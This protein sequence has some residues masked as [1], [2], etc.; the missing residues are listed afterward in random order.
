MKKSTWFLAG[1]ALC[2]VAIP[3]LSQAAPLVFEGGDGI[4]KGKHIVLI[5]GD[6]EYRSEEVMPMLG[7]ILSK[8]HGFK[9]SVVF[10]MSKDGTFIDPKNQESLEGL[11]ALE[12]ADL[13]MIATRF[14]K[15]AEGMNFVDDYLA[16][17]KPVIGLR[18]ATHGF[19]GLSGKYAR[20]NNGYGGE[21]W[22][23]GFGREVLGEKW[24]NHHGHH[25]KESTMGVIVESE[26]DHPVLR[27]IGKWQIWGPTDVYG[28]RLPLPG[29][30]KPLVLGSVLEGMTPKDKAVSGKKNDPM[31]PVVWTKSYQ[32]KDG[33]KG[34]VL[35][36]TMGAS[37][38]FIEPGLRRLVINGVL[39][40]LGMEDKI[41]GKENVDVVGRFVQS[42]FG[43]RNEKG[44]W[45]EK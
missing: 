23:G 21:E 11:E 43:F 31:M 38:D 42:K 3:G 12:S 28:V 30:S 45:K 22:K 19:N 14:R 10:S 20:Y 1:L 16:K 32:G 26:K 7:K 15:P 17:G 13:M 6:E 9:C 25:G 41:T 39:W 24:I 18:T 33:T 4:G 29:D 8:R 27:G 40:A 37:E 35:T 44:Y 36:T 2:A 5:S 34:R